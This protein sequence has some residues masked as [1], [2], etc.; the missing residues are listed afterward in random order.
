MLSITISITQRGYLLDI[1]QRSLHS[2]HRGLTTQLH[3]SVSG[4]VAYLPSLGACQTWAEGFLLRSVDS[5]H[6]WQL[7]KW[8]RQPTSPQASWHSDGFSLTRDRAYCIQDRGKLV[9]WR[10]GE[11]EGVEYTWG[12]EEERNGITQ[13]V[14]KSRSPSQV[15]HSHLYPAVMASMEAQR[16]PGTQVTL[17]AHLSRALGCQRA[18]LKSTCRGLLQKKSGSPTPSQARLKTNPEDC[19]QQPLHRGLWAPSLLYAAQHGGFSSQTEQ[20]SN[21]MLKIT[22]Q[23]IFWVINIQLLSSAF[24]STSKT[25]SPLWEEQK[26]LL[27]QMRTRLLFCFGT[28]RNQLMIAN[29]KKQK[30]TN[31]FNYNL[32]GATRMASDY[33]T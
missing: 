2:C 29:I 31:L 14:T 22:I 1:P 33:F 32:S 25:P 11:N 16:G 17:C 15:Q 5:S 19:A 4:A 23:N 12:E 28:K 9:M 13:Q 8:H 7:L 18:A 30:T 26:L 6:A 21:Q 3:E 10:A 24:S 20:K 27:K